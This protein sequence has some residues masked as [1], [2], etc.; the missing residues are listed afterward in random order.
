MTHGCSMKVGRTASSLSHCA[1]FDQLDHGGPCA[2]G[3]QDAILMIDVVAQAS[4][5]VR[6]AQGSPIGLSKCRHRSGTAVK[7][8]E[9]TFAKLVLPSRGGYRT[10]WY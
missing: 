1:M 5:A 3:V 9:L 10:R 4:K 6:Y 8:H 2:F 7:R